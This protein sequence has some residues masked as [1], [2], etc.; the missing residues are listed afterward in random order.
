MKSSVLAREVLFPMRSLAE[1]TTQTL[2]TVILFLK[3]HPSVSFFSLSLFV[4]AS[5]FIFSLI[6]FV[7]MA[8]S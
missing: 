6:L 2:A 1:A 5:F 4:I 8:L 3:S 7:I